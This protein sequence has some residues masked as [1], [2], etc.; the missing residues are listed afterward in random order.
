MQ[1]PPSSAKILKNEFENLIS[2]QDW[3]SLLSEGHLDEFE[4]LLYEKFMN[5]YDQFSNVFISFLSSTQTFNLKQKEK[6]KEL[7]LKKLVSRQVYLQLRTGT[8]IKFESL[9][10]KKVPKGYKKNVIFPCCFG[11]VLK[12]SHLHTQA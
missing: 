12:K 4:Q 8:K 7:G 5:L 3:L 9:Y 6:A 1:L 2:V 11:I 10:A